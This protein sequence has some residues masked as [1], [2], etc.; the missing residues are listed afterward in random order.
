M[1]DTSVYERYMQNAYQFSASRNQETTAKL[2][3]AVFKDGQVQSFNKFKR[4]AEQ[5]CNVE[6]E[7]HLRVEYETCRTAAVGGERWRQIEKLKDYYPY[8]VYR[9][10]MDNREREDHVELEG[11]VYRIGDK[12]G[13]QIFFPNGFNCRC[14]GVS[15]DDDRIEE[16]GLSI[17]T[18]NEAAQ[19]LKNNVDEQ[20]RFNPAHQGMLPKKDVTNGNSW[21]A[22]S[23]GLSKPK[24]DDN[25][26]GLNSRITAASGLHQ[27]MT[28]V[29]QWKDKY[30]TDKKGN[31][32][33]QN[34]DTFTNVILNNIAIHHIQ[35]HPRGFEGLPNTIENPDEIWGMWGDE[36]QMIVLRNYITFG[37]T[38]SYIVQTKDGI[39]TDAF[40]VSNG[41]L[42]KFRK[43]LIY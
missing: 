4:D 27:V 25:P 40:A 17:R 1:L 10:V 6:N 34:K 16:E 35:K 13:D 31:V 26:E 14:D 33:F 32:I 8:W 12:N 42:N 37:K 30:S 15:I 38:A 3:S 39:I 11:K 43:G 20:F 24:A 36:K 9:G 7:V 22:N 23:F 28:I 2:Q 41:S 19:D 29:N 18:E 21:D 5:I